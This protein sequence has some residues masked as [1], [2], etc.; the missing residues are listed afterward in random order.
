MASDISIANQ[1]LGFLGAKPIIS[2]DDESKE[3][4]LMKANYAPIRDAVLESHN[5]TF[6][7]KWLEVPAMADPPLS[8]FANAYPIPSEVLR[9]IF[10]G[11]NYSNPSNNWRVEGGNIVTNDSS[12]K[13]QAVAVVED[14]NKFSSLF[15]QA[16]AQRLAGDLAIAITS[17]RTLS[18]HHLK[19]FQIKL[20]EA[21]S[22]DGLQ[23]QPRRITSSWIRNARVG[24]GP[25][26]AGP[27]V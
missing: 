14:P 20:K 8:E 1:A 5:W 4:A 22:R 13:I 18:E 3:A 19:L 7:T 9:I 16:L 24:S 6:A 2:F 17:S 15:V 12:V 26:S 23:G 21:V 10:V 11:Q 27:Y 25:R